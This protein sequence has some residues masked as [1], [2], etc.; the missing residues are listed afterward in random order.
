MR[1]RKLGR[2][3]LEVSELGLGCMGMSFAY[4]TVEEK[5]CLEVLD[6]SLELGINFWDTAEAYGPFKNE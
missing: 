6:R 4:H 1:K 3:G 5:A 2:Q